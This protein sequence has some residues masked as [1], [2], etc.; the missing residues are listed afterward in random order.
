MLRALYRGALLACPA[1]FR[2]EYGPEMEA[3]FADCV[4]RERTRAPGL[5]WRLRCVHGLA[6]TLALGVSLRFAAPAPM[7]ARAHRQRRF[8]MR[9]TDV[10]TSLRRMRAHPVRSALIVLMLG[11]GIGAT[12][13]IFSVVYGV[14]LK[15]LPFP[16]LDRIVQVRHAIPARSLTSTLTEAAVWDIRERSRAFEAFGGWHGASFSLAGEPPERVTGAQ[17]SVG[18]LRALGV[19][20]VTGRLFEPGEDDPGRSA[21]LVILGHGLWT[22]RFAAD[23][24]I[25]GQS[26]SLG[27]RPHQVI[28]VLPPGTPWLDTDVFVPFQRRIEANRGSWEYQAV[29]RL[30][31]GVSIDGARADLERVARDLEAA[32]PATST[33]STFT[34]ESAE[35]WVATPALRRTLWILL[36]AVGLL[37]A[38]ACVNVTNLLLAEGA[39]RARET[40]VRAALGARRGDLVRATLTESLLLSLAGAGTGLLVAL[41]M[42]RAFTTFDPGG[43]PRLADAALNGWA[44]GAC[45]LAAL[46]VA[47]VA[48]LVPSLRAPMTDVLSSLGQGQRTVG[49]RQHAR[50][51]GLLV[52]AEVALS[53]ALLVGAGL[54][55]RSLGQVLT[56]DRGFQTDQRL[57]ATVSLPGSYPEPRRAQITTTILAGLEARPDVVSVAIVSGRPLSGGSTGLGIVA[58]DQPALPESSVPWATW[59]II[60]KDYFRAMGLPLLAG[61]EFTDQDLMSK[62][63]RAIISQRLAELLWPGQN[64]VGRT[65]ILWKGQ[66]DLPAEVIGVVGNMRERGLERD[67]TLAVYFPAGG[68]LGGTTT[69]QFVM[70]TRGE[71]AAAV[72]ALRSVVAGIDPQLPVSGIRTLEETVTESVAQRRFTMLLLIVFAVLAIALALAGVYGVLAYVVARQTPEIGVRLALGARPGQVVHHVFAR[73]M[74]PVL[75]GIVVGLVAVGWASQLMT[76]LLFGIAPTDPVTYVAASAGL[77]AAAALACYLPAR[78]ALRVD[79]LVALR[80][81]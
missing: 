77:V 35:A 76:S 67:P 52:G 80:A 18:F 33:G 3:A 41:G 60:T 72:S 19:R 38:I 46:A 25:V 34:V 20:A 39:N 42:L 79:P 10:R 44:L 69:L 27:G 64:P 22:R 26:I 49:Y 14:L 36:G 70:H 5:V 28:G 73:G 21:D 45:L 6:G 71:P 4:A 59:R 56:V 23:P 12:T 66:G 47:L 65:A 9:L 1:A 81:E 37:L 13:A 75:I 63:W 68:V 62:P 16:E 53:L 50:I 40:A 51:R 32:Y 2:R 48:G 78:R 55:A 7:P 29:G 24:M 15:P 30:R 57:L 8:P 61:R 17:V 11:L 43:V 58:G 74:R 54:M 31:P